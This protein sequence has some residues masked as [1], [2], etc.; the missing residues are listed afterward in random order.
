MRLCTSVPLFFCAFAAQSVFEI[1]Q[2]VLQGRQDAGDTF[3]VL[4]ELSRI[5]R[6]SGNFL[7]TRP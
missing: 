1:L 3:N 6:G 2:P 5:R 4:P 7:L